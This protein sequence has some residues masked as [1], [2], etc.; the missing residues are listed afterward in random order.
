MPLPAE[1]A[2]PFIAEDIREGEAAGE[3]A[4][5]LLG[6]CEGED[7]CEESVCGDV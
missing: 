5:T 3:L 4:S 1:L 7:V 6:G 2:E